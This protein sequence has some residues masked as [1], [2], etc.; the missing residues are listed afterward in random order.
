[1]NNGKG[2]LY[3][4]VEFY[5]LKLMSLFIFMYRKLLPQPLVTVLLC[6]AGVMRTLWYP[7]N[8]QLLFQENICGSTCIH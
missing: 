1:M 7:L 4:I 6:V 3:I 8:P 5:L 2:V